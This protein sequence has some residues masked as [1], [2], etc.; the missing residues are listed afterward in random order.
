MRGKEGGTLV[1]LLVKEKGMDKF[2]AEL[3]GNCYINV[4]FI[5]FPNF[6]TRVV[7]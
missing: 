3:M 7:L 5:P 6:K 1:G 2:L 4:F